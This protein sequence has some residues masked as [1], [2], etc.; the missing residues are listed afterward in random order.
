[1]YGERE[2]RCLIRRH[3]EEESSEVKTMEEFENPLG[4]AQEEGPLLD[5]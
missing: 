1:M 4:E 5:T 2:V 3:A